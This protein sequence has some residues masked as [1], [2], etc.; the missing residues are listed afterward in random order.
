MHP[1]VQFEVQEFDTLNEVNRLE[2]GTLDLS[3]SITNNID[4]QKLNFVNFKTTDILFYTSVHNKL[5]EK[6]VIPIS[7]LEGEPLILL[8]E[9]SYQYQA[10]MELFQKNHLKPNIIHRSNQLN[11]IRKF[12]QDGL[13]SSLLI[14]ELLECD[15]SMITIPFEASPTVYIGIMWKKGMHLSALMSNFIEFVKTTRFFT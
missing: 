10:V 6:S 9:N 1:D 8:N 4:R 15:D 5:A 11:T 7:L 13:A 12:I 2:V 14:G 3:L